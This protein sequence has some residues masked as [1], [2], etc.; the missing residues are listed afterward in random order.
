MTAPIEEF[1][2]YGM[3]FK[4]RAGSS[5]V[6]NPASSSQHISRHGLALPSA[7]VTVSA[8]WTGEE[9]CGVY[10]SRN[11][12]LANIGT[13][14]AKSGGGVRSPVVAQFGGLEGDYVYLYCRPAWNGEGSPTGTITVIPTAT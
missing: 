10:L 2:P 8:S 7:P 9:E 1:M 4:P 12:V 13:I 3:T 14:P 5:Y 6:N 11:G